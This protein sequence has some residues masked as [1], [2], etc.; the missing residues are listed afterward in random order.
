MAPLE[1]DVFVRIMVTPAA[2]TTAKEHHA[3]RAFAKLFARRHISWDHI[4]KFELTY[5]AGLGVKT[6]DCQLSL[7]YATKCS[8]ATIFPPTTNMME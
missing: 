5:N 8:C 2:A 7:I 4:L 3:E 6:S 1:R